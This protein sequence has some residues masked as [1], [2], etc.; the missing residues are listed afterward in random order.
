MAT[1]IRLSKST[2]A[3]G[4]QPFLTGARLQEPLPLTAFVTIGRGPENTVAIDDSY[5][6]H[7]HAR[8][9]QKSFGF[10]LRDLQSRNGTYVNGVAIMEAV[11]ND[12]DCIRIGKSEF[13]FSN[14]QPHSTLSLTSKNPNYSLQL[15][16][17]PS[18]AAENI[19]VL[20]LGPSGV[21]KE[22]IA[23]AVHD[24]SSRR[25]GPFVSVNCSALSESLVESELFGH[26]RGSFTGAQNDRKGAFETARGGTLFL[27]EIG[28]LPLQLQPKLLRALENQ[29]I[30][31]VGS[32]STIQTDIRIVAATHQ[33]LEGQAQ[34]GAF[35]FDLFYRLQGMTLRPPALKDR[36]EDFETL[37]FT[38][39]RHSKVR[40]SHGAIAELKKHSWPGNIRELKNMVA[41]ARVLFGSQTVE[42][43]HV[44][45][46]IDSPPDKFPDLGLKLPSGKF[47]LKSLERELI[48]T[49]LKANKG[50]QR[51]TAD[52]LGIPKSTLHDRI[53]AYAI[54]V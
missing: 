22:L 32:D 35:R 21:G 46:L 26:I 7:R 47:S 15:K 40:F 11:L 53:R 50:N 29:E 44:T 23:R 2:A 13:V 34:R 8:I 6:S 3:S 49:R 51:R 10:V 19:P 37:L 30:R 48:M 43:E 17:L 1:T 27:D 38:F 36:L 54:E 12:Q 33:D 5:T 45:R 16:N 24:L 14:S 28:D 52:D 25:E 9:E 31:P 20:I 4:V 18:I 41:R 42:A 39:A